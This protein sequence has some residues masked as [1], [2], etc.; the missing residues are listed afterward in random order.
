MF[1]ST[2]NLTG[3]SP[4][5]EITLRFGDL[6]LKVSPYGASLRGLWREYTDGNDDPII[7]GYTG[8]KGKIGGQ[9]DVLIPFPGR[10]REGRYTF[11]NH[12]YQM[13]RND[14][15]GPNAIH[16]FLRLVPWEIAEQSETEV[17]FTVSLGANDRPGYPFAL[18]VTVRY[19]L[20]E[21]GMGCRFTVTNDG[22]QTA[23]VGAGFHPYFTVGSA[24]IDEDTL[25]VPF[26]SILE[27]D[28]GIL[29]TGRVLAVEGTPMDFREPRVIGSTRFNTCYLNPLRD[30]DGR[31]QVRLASPDTGR[32]L[33]VWMDEAFNYVVLYSGD[34]LPETHRRRSLAIEPMTCGS[35]AF[36]HG[37]WGLVALSPGQSFAGSWGVAVD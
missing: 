2:T 30:P 10:V 20:E 17:A 8:A 12:T 18:R 32:R 26:D 13:E 34:P 31:L 28:S 37:E 6:R 24:H 7:T 22:E 3:D 21:S 27:F 19:W 5:A 35:D 14:K 11:E 23:P 25:Q 29:P 16:G 33:A 15:D 4:D 36:N 1:M 9:G